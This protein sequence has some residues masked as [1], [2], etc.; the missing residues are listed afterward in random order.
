[1]NSKGIASKLEP[2]GG[3]GVV[4]AIRVKDGA[5]LWSR[6][7]RMP[8]N[9]WV[10]YH[11]DSVLVPEGGFVG[12]P[13]ALFAPRKGHV[14]NGTSPP[15]KAF[16]FSMAM[17]NRMRGFM[18]K[19]NVTGALV[20]MSAADGK[21]QWRTP[22]PPYGYNAD[23]G[24]ELG[25]IERMKAQSQG[26]LAGR[27]VC[28]P[29]QFGG[30]TVSSNGILYVG[31]ADGFLWAFRADSGELVR[32]PPRQP[33]SRTQPMS[34]PRSAR[35]DSPACSPETF[36]LIRFSMRAQVDRFDTRAG[37]LHGGPSFAPGMMVVASCDG[38]FVFN[39]P[40]KATGLA[41]GLRALFGRGTK[42]VPRP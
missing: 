3:P 34:Q 37:F 12:L 2:L 8:C 18:R 22:F 25:I 17:G 19:P 1:M 9:T 41:T 28:L 5:P 7:L 39:A 6:V 13:R 15:E 23:I 10:T 4:R 20:S 26:V 42:R 31:R 21:V 14:W 16:A 30:P 27:T 29:A 11:K 33:R 32:P 40:Q 24:D 35:C 38:V 36:P